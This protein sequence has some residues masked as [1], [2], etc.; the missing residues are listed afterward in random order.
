MTASFLIEAAVEGLVIGGVYALLGLGFHLMFGVLKRI[1]L[2]Y[3]TTL[4]ASV[5]LAA[6]LVNGY[7]LWWGLALPL[8]L[9]LGVAISAAIERLAF[10]WVRGDGRFSMVAT[11]GIWMLLEELLIRSPG[12]G[13]GQSMA[14]P[15]DLVMVPLGPLTLRL[16][17]IVAFVLSLALCVGIYALLFRSSAGLKIRVVVEDRALAGLLGIDPERVTRWIFALAASVGVLA[18][19]AFATAQTAVDIHFGMWATLKGLVILVL[20]GVGSLWGVVGAGLGLGVLERL[21]SELAGPGYRDLIGYGLMVALLALFPSGFG[22][23][24]RPRTR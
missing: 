8:A 13:R 17:Y 2:A 7:G 4:M 19:Y 1:N 21:G 15:L 5:Y 12:R 16:D 6:M 10:G 22:G 20:G 23:R 24:L 14:N 18:G 11:L 3:G 9:I